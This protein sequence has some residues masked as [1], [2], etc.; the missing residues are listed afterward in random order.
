M[1]CGLDHAKLSPKCWSPL[2][3]HQQAMSAPNTPWP[4]SALWCWSVH[5][6]V[7]TSQRPHLASGLS[8]S[9]LVPPLPPRLTWTSCFPESW[10]PGSCWLSLWVEAH[11]FSLVL[12]PG[13][14]RALW[15]LGVKEV[16]QPFL[17]TRQ[18]ALEFSTMEEAVRCLPT[19]P[20]TRDPYREL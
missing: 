15:L 16:R 17:L 19:P 2:T 20:R 6:A 18:V 10:S 7:S 9:D 8:S 1:E 13:P 5:L 3:F 11:G 14:R 4:Q 12:D